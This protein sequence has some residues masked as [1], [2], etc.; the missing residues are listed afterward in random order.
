MSSILEIISFDFTNDQYQILVNLKGRNSFISFYQM[1]HSDGDFT[2][3]EIPESIY[4]LSQEMANIQSGYAKWYNHKYKRFGL[5]F[6]RRHTK[7]LIQTEEVY[8]VTT[9]D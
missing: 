7:I 1:K 6:G 9:K 5:V 4:I 3:D 8:V 2:E